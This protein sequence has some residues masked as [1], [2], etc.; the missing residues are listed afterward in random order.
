MR[1]AVVLFNLGGPDKPEA[2]RPFLFNLFNDPAII[3]APNPVR[4][5]L[6]W[7]VS[8]RRAPV[9]RDIYAKLGGGSPLLENTLAQAVALE[10][11]LQFAEIG[12]VR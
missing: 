9:A 12:E 10:E 8:A 2:V 3:G 5:L 6:A 4:W 1:T 7:F 11:A